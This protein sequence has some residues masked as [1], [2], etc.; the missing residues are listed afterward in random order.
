MP[1]LFNFHLFIVVRISSC[2]TVG[3]L[4]IGDVIAIGDGKRLSRLYLSPQ[5]SN[6]CS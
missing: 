4:S 2:D 3:Y 6:R 1:M 5:F